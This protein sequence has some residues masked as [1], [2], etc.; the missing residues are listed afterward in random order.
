V[1]PPCGPSTEAS[2]ASL[3][4]VAAPAVEPAGP[5]GKHD[6]GRAVDV[7]RESHGRSVTLDR[8]RVSRRRK[9]RTKTI[10][11]NHRP[12]CVL[13]LLSLRASTT[14]SGKSRPGKRKLKS[15]SRGAARWG[16]PERQGWQERALRRGLPARSGPA[17]NFK[18]GLW[19]HSVKM[20]HCLGG[21]CGCCAS[22]AC[23][24]QMPS[25][26]PPPQLGSLGLPPMDQTRQAS[27]HTRQ[28]AQ[29]L[30]GYL[31]RAI[32]VKPRPRA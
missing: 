17:G 4:Q 3:R 18:L 20:H 6:Q 21:A 25:Q 2:H 16:Q 32:R 27:S 5:R 13:C 22:A 15:L 23:S 7:S 28:Q 31:L 24:T 8:A 19:S 30:L 12:M 26:A 14:D 29:A 10:L 11:P 1:H 9:S